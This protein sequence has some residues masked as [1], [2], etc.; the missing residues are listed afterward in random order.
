MVKRKH[1]VAG[2]ATVRT[3]V[4]QIERGTL[5]PGKRV[6]PHDLAYR[7]GSSTTPVREALCQLVGREILIER[8]REGFYV[9]PVTSGALRSLYAAHGHVMEMIL[10]GWRAGMRLGRQTASPWR[11]FA[12]IAAAVN[13]DALIGM[14]RYLAGRLAVARKHEVSHVTWET[15][16]P[17]LFEALR[18]SDASAASAISRNFHQSCEAAAFQI[19][20]SM[21]D[22]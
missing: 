9:A 16:A 14:Q 20:Q 2:P 21:S 12:R 8:P 4:L 1:H 11:L 7:L 17:G 10:L 19:W 3:V 13:D 15:T 22:V 18:A 6:M 5:R